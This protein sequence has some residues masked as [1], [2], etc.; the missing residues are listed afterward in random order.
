MEVLFERESL[1][2]EV[3]ATPMTAL[4]KKYLLSDSG[5]RKVCVALSIPLPGKGHWAKVQAGHRLPIPPLPPTDGRTH[6]SSRVPDSTDK[7]PFD[8]DDWLRD[9]IAFEAAPA[10]A[11]VV[12][13]DLV[14]PHPL[15]RSAAAAV[16]TEINGLQR[17]RAHAERPKKRKPGAPWEPDWG[18]LSRPSWRRYLETGVMEIDP[19]VLP[20]R[21][22]IESADRALRLWDTLLKA[23]VARGL[24]IEMGD[25]RVE[26]S[27][28]AETVKLRMS[29]KVEHEKR[30]V[31]LGEN[32]VLAR[33]PTGRLRIFLGVIASETSIEDSPDQAL[34]QQLNDFM[35]RIYRALASSRR[36]HA[37]LAERRHREEQV[38]QLRAQ[39]RAAAEEVARLQKTEVERTRELVAEAT[40]WKDA[41]RILAYVNHIR[42]SASA[43]G[44]TLP[45][46]W[47]AWAES[48]AASMDPTRKRLE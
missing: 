17:S 38:A 18:A 25:R 46:E 6:F 9:R 41:Q 39:E 14:K 31:E 23:C 16:R 36:W 13:P 43:R 42:G 10:N 15:V 4:A 29:E 37:A 3:W 7:A 26:V 20:L 21:V 30:P 5:I 35:A 19:A 8:T 22:S 32:T 48:V 11:I 12:F 28:G 2:K 33:A 40:A 44:M 45:A 1:Y 27:D 47:A 24:R 34:E